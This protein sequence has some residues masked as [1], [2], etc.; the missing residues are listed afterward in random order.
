M[1]MA[2][3]PALAKTDALMA[4]KAVRAEAGR[5]AKGGSANVRWT[6]YLFLLP[7]V[8]FLLAFAAY[9]I[10]TTV[11]YSFRKVTVPGLMTGKLP[12]VGLANYQQVLTDPLFQHSVLIALIFTAASV[13]FQFIFGFSFALLFN[14]RF[15]LRGLLRGLVMLAWVMPLIVVG[16]VFKWMFQSGTGI[17]N[18]GLAAIDPSLPVAWLEQPRSALLA[19][20]ITN[21]WLGIPFNMA[22]LLAGLQGISPSVYEAARV[23]GASTWQ[24]FRYVTLPLMRGPSLIVITLSIILTLNVFEIILIITGGGPGQATTVSTFYA[25]QQAFQFFKVGPAS[26]VTV[27]SFCLL[28]LVSAV[29]LRLLYLGE[30]G[31][32]R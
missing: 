10:V 5:R 30:R 26:A 12:F 24:R 29:Y 8:V 32:H 9:P 27:L 13:L 2:A 28:A 3:P 11:V 31:T 18:A 6:D 14:N 23:D 21:I 1:T 22:M 15:P 20:I 19:V 16:T 4:G 7:A 25:Y 17:I